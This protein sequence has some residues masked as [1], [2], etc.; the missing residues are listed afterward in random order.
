M[1]VGEEEEVRDPE[2]HEEEV[3]VEVHSRIHLF[4]KAG[5]LRNHGTWRVPEGVAE[6]KEH[7]DLIIDLHCA[8]GEGVSFAIRKK[9]RQ[10]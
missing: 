7:G 1:A 8:E 10:I 6:V 9:N 2:G 4:L 5:A 3:K